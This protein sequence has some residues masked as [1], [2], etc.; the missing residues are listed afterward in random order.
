M[1][2]S[3]EFK[4]ALYI[5][6]SK[7]DEK[8]KDNQSESVINQKAMLIEYAKKEKLKVVDVYIDDGYTGL[9]TERPD[10]QRMIN[11]IKLG[12]VNMV[13][14]KDLSRLGRDYIAVG[15]YTER[16]FPEN[17]VRY[18]ALTDNMDTFEN[19]NNDFMPFKSVFNEMYSK[20]IS[21]KINSVF[22]TKM[23]AG[24]YMASRTPFGYIK[25]KNE[26]NKLVIDSET[27]PIIQEIFKRY[28]YGESIINIA[29]DL[30]KRKIPT[31]ANRLKIKIN[32]SITTN[33]WKESVIRR[34]LQND[35]Y[36][37]NTTS[38]KT[39]K[40]SFKSKVRVRL[41]KEDWIIIENTHEP[42]I[43]REIFDKVQIRIN[44]NKNVKRNSV[45]SPLKGLIYC[46]DCKGRM[47]VSYSISR[48]KKIKRK[49]FRCSNGNRYYPH[50]KCKSHYI[51]EE[52]LMDA[53]NKEVKVILERYVNRDKLKNIASELM[54]INNNETEN[55]KQIKE[56]KN[57]IKS[58][59]ENL[60]SLY[61]DKLCG[62]LK[63]EDFERIY[64]K[65][66]TQRE[67]LEMNL[68]EIEKKSN[69]YVS[70]VSEV[71]LN[72]IVTEYISNPNA[73]LLFD[74]IN[75][76]EVVS[77][78]EINIIFNFKELEAVK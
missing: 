26:K 16:F 54:N 35:V 51:R 60:D 64:S 53:I 29:N 73:S 22:K 3:N 68:N 77:K 62:K 23:L 66:C 40:V 46:S 21:K 59:S 15:E 12:K 6:L 14:T 17:N 30:T 67:L 32:K 11:D 1:K 50:L 38:H 37:G 20:D 31:P 43:S 55:L 39:K 42:I 70:G 7:E 78:N 5:R 36:I 65:I 69:V 13:V 76:V 58:I 25:S 10:F 63:E 41:P 44:K 33:F 72:K 4:V 9:N 8:S 27:A 75:R 56:L 71:E 28:L 19:T 18:V 57:Q 49:Y 52:K 47:T 48:D 24:E 2:I 61:L 34:I 45:D 74:I